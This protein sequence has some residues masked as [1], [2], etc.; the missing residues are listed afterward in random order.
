M[1]S[2]ASNVL[3]LLYL[4]S[5]SQIHHDGSWSY[6]NRVP[7]KYNPWKTC[8][9]T[10]E[11]VLADKFLLDEKRKFSCE[12]RHYRKAVFQTPS[13]KFLRLEETSKLMIQHN[14]TVAYAG[15]SLPAQLYTNAMCSAETHGFSMASH[16]HFLHDIFLRNDIPCDDRCLTNTTFLEQKAFKHPC[17]GCRNGT[18]YDYHAYLQDP[19]T[20]HNRAA[21]MNVSALVV[22]NGAWYNS[23]QGI[24]NSTSTYIETLQTTGPIL[25]N[26]HEQ[27]GMHIFWLGLVPP[28]VDVT[29]MNETDYG[30][31]WI[32]FEEKDALAKSILEPY[33]VTFIDTN[34][35]LKTRKKLDPWVSADGMHWW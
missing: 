30:Y 29:K 11:L 3:G 26:L 24:I 19:K 12:D 35:L 34:M 9:Q 6:H 18:R 21:A 25:K 8:P 17:W 4:C 31:E 23:F 7:A 16:T 22:G 1:A 28:N 13:C 27:Y 15:D 33:G 2:W 5:H 14:F 32:H 20:W 10:D